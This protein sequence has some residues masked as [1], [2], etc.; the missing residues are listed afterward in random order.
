MPFG[1]GD[2]VS[3]IVAYI[4]VGPQAILKLHQNRQIPILRRE[5]YCL[6]TTE[7]HNVTLTH[8]VT[9]RGIPLVSSHSSRYNEYLV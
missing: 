8:L 9:Q 3:L 1:L 5:E 2:G 7:I 4:R 6:K